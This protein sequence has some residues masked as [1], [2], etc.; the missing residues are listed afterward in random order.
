MMVGTFRYARKCN[1]QRVDD[2][3]NYENYEWAFYRNLVLFGT[4][5]ER[6]K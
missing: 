6:P 2:K 5:L 1:Q 4:V 3:M